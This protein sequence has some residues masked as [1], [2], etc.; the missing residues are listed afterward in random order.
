MS[1]L[2]EIDADESALAELLFDVGGD[3]SDEDVA[4]AVDAWMAELGDA[5]AVKL[6]GYGKVIGELEARAAA[7]T[8]EAD[9]LRNRAAA[10]LNRVKQLKERLLAY[11]R[12]R[13][14]KAIGGN[15]FRFAVCANGGKTPLVLHVPTEELPEQFREAL[16]TY[17]PKSDDIRAALESGADLS[18]ATLGDRGYHLRVR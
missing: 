2:Y 7:K 8:A 9:R 1:T 14:H 11:M 18:F 15:L 4:A 3:V 13:G 6:D 17:R 12:E 5:R 16:T 10:E